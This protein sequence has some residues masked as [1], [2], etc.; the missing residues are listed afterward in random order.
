MRISTKS[1]RKSI[2]KQDFP[3][4]LRLISTARERSD[5]D[6]P[7]GTEKLGFSVQSDKFL[8]CEDCLKMI[9]YFLTGLPKKAKSLV[10]SITFQVLSNWLTQFAIKILSYARLCMNMF[11]FSWILSSAIIM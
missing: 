8:S 6:A 3:L 4:K 9:P 7:I 2:R 10:S 1:R 11:I 5:R